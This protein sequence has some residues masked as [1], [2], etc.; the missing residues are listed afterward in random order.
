VTVAD[1]LDARS[2]APPAQLLNRLRAALGLALVWDA[3]EVPHAFVDAA[4]TLLATLVRDGCVKRD[5]ALD[6]LAVDAL[7]T[8]A[9]EAASDDPESLDTRAHDAMRCLA[10]LA[11][12]ASP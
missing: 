3:A 11:A 10:E 1:W 7:V 5:R 9:F 2:P 8:Y 6:L 4:E 12:Q